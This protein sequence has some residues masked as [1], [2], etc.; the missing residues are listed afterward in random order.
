M[1]THGRFL[2]TMR[3]LRSRM[4][5]ASQPPPRAVIRWAARCR[6]RARWAD[7]MWLETFVRRSRALAYA[8]RAGKVKR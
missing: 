3:R 1:K 4:R 6:A 2:R 7:A 5:R 8:A